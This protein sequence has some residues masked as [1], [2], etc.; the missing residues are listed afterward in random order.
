MEEEEKLCYRQRAEKA[1]G[2]EVVLI[3]WSPAMDVV[4]LAFAD[5]S[6]RTCD[7]S[8]TEITRLNIFIITN[9]FVGIIIHSYIVC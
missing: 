4:A 7:Y 5:H 9:K 2:G 1:T 3:H 6:V 8:V